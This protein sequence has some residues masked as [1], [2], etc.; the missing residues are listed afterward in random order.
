M[1]APQ[2]HVT[3]IGIGAD[4]WAGVP[5]SVRAQIIAADVVLGGDRHLELIPPVHDQV[6]RPWPRPLSGLDT[7]LTEFG[8][9]HVV[10][11][12]SGDPF[13]SGIGTTLAELLG[14]GL[15]AIPAVSSVALARSRMRWS[16]E[17]S[18]VVT[19]VGRD[20]NAV[21]RELSP[22]ARL[23]VLSS[24]ESTPGAVAAI[25]TEHG[26]GAS[27]MTVLGNLGAEDETRTEFVA[28]RFGD[29]VAAAVIPRLHVLAIEVAGTADLDAS[30]APGLP[31][32]AFEHDGQLTK[33]DQRASAL[34]RLAPRPGALLWDVGAGAGS[35]GI[36]W[37]RAHPT[38]AAIAVEHHA[39]RAARIVR[40]AARLGVPRLQL[41]SGRAPDALA[42]LPTPD[43][44]FIGGG[45]TAP[46]LL[47]R[48]RAALAPGGRLVVHGVTFATEELL[49]AAFRD[50]G[51]ELTRL[52]VEHAAPL[53]G[54]FH[55][56][57]P[58]RAIT[59]WAWTRSEQS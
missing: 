51:G 3:V 45:A 8:D 22:G 31:D 16:A 57:Q 19:L 58:T 33:R 49:L 41:V 40:N 27:T 24:D 32:D 46:G 26:L 37:L 30:W 38:T 50:H 13:V 43:A 42:E 10:A 12:A 56:W 14:D 35:V 55:G 15:D 20:P 44:I 7:L 28:D 18:T 6:R 39:D 21:R 23:L 25:L 9:A 59:Q 34:A 11:L 36:E 54:R 29:T 2:P 17:S 52:S 5:A 48:C 1:S 53:G 4:G 47:D